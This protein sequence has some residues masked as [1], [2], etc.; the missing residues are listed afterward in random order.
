MKNN[1]YTEITENYPEIPFMYPTGYEDAVVG[2]EEN[3]EK[4][5]I[6]K[7]KMHRIDIEQNDMTFIESIEWH[8]YNTFYAGHGEH[9]PIFMSVPE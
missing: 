2:W 6:S 3:T 4:L 7:E 1:I 5:I 9:T 8:D